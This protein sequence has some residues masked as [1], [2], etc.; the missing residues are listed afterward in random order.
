MTDENILVDILNKSL[1]INDFVAFNMGESSKIRIGKIKK[2]TPKTLVLIELDHNNKLSSF[3]QR[4]Y[5]SKSRF[6]KLSDL[7]IATLQF[8]S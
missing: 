4:I 7:E 1:Q 8:T 2:I 5:Y 3:S 6:V